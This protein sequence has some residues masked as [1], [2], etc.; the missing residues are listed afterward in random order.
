MDKEHQG[1]ILEGKIYGT[2]PRTEAE[3]LMDK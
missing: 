2:P 3:D 1:N